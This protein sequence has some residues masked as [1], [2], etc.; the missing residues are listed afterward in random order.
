MAAQAHPAGSESG[1]ADDRGIFRDIVVGVDG[2]PEARAAHRLGA[3]LRADGGRLLGL[4]VAEVHAATLTGLEAANWTSWIRSAADE[5][6]D[7]AAAEL[8]HLPHASVRALDGRPA[9]VLLSAAR[10]RGADLVA[11]GAGGGR[12][13]GLL[14]GSTV[15]RVARESPCSVL[16]ARGEPD[17]DA[18][19]Q[20]IVVGVD[21]SA[22]SADA[23]AVGRVLADSFGAQVRRIAATR[24]EQ[25]DPARPVRA[26]VDARRP[27]PALVDASH[28]ADLLIVGS[29]GLRGLSALGS[30][31][32]RVAHQAACPVLIVRVR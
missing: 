8:A 4:S 12:I 5:I 17:P 21:G 19:P 9:D 14:F 26:E 16:V 20:R 11:V 15:T 1:A 13:A 27:V 30:V 3:R 2:S 18:F 10:T 22:H 25:F 32:E 6:R 28:N 31:A 29:R 24:G 7:E 23:E